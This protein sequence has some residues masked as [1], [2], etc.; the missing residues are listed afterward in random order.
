VSVLAGGCSVL[1]LSL[2]THV[3]CQAYVLCRG[4]VVISAREL[5]TTL[6]AF[7]KP[8]ILPRKQRKWTYH[9]PEH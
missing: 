8:A 7:P 1:V 3:R 4:F 5:P 9:S 6:S 2:V